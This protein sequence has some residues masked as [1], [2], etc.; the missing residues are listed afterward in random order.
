M[1]IA[2]LGTGAWGSGLAQVVADNGHDVQMWGKDVGEVD[3][4]QNNHHNT[5]F[6]SAEL[7]HNIHAS[8]DLEVI[9]GSRVVLMAVPSIALE[10]VAKQVSPYLED[11]VIVVNVAKGFHPENH[12]RLSLVLQ[13]AFHDKKTRIV[14][15]IGP[16]HAE[17]VVLRLLTSVNAVSEDDEASRMIQEIFS[18]HYFRVYRNH[19]LIGAE[20]GVAL[21]NVMA[22]ASGILDGLGQGDN[23]RA[24]LMT[25]GLAEMSRYGIY[26]GGK[27]ETFLGLDGVGDLIVTC[28]SHHSRNFMAGYEIGKD[29]SAKNF[30]ANNQKTVE[31]MYACK[32]VYVEAKK[33]HIDM[34][35]TNEVYAILYEGKKPSQAMVDLMARE[36]KAE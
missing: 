33:H 32:I 1:K 25:R 27:P 28:T 29:D 10:P 2:I 17:E 22:I 36:L 5:K 6:F 35:I 3:D 30:L 31:G 34:P 15:L 7:N 4:I 9:R 19:D 14:S 8:T 12:E 16:S 20:I 21:K 26:F 23:A 13:K 18:N 11:G 24:A